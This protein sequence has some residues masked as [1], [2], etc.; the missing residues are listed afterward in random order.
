MAEVPNSRSVPSGHDEQFVVQ[1]DEDLHC[2]ICSLPSKEPVLTRCGHRFCRQCLEEFLR[3]QEQEGH[4]ITCPL[5]REALE[6][7]KDIFPDKL[8]E[9]K[10]LSHVIKCPNECCDWR[11]ELR[12][13]E[14]HLASCPWKTVSCTNEKCGEH[15]ARKDLTEHV[16]NT[17]VWRILRCL[18]CQEHHPQCQMEAHL[19]NCEGLLTACPNNCGIKITT[20]KVSDHVENTCPLTE[21]P[22]PYNWLGCS[23]KIQREVLESH[24]QSE[25]RYHLHLSCCKLND[26]KNEV[27]NLQLE[28]EELQGQEDNHHNEIEGRAQALQYQ[29]EE[30]AQA[31]QNQFE[32]RVQALQNQFEQREQALQNQFEERAQ[33]LQNQ[34]EERVQAVQNQFEERVQALQNQFEEREQALQ[35][36]FEER[37][38]A[39]E[40][41]FEDREQALQNHFEDRLHA[42]QKHFEDRVQ[43]LENHFEERINLLTLTIDRLRKNLKFASIVFAVTVVILAALSG[44]SNRESAVLNRLEKN[45]MRNVEEQSKLEMKMDEVQRRLEGNVTDLRSQSEG[46][47][48]EAQKYL[49]EKTDLLTLDSGEH[50][51]KIREFE[52]KIQALTTR[53]DSPR[54][55]CDAKATAWDGPRADGSI[56]Y[57]DQHHVECPHGMFVASFQLKKEYYWRRGQR[58]HKVGYHYHCCKFIL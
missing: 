40:N 34:F 22:C 16:A 51:Q 55:V 31:L 3:R 54:V 27:R 8:A 37:V 41:H 56:I 13:K 30:R 47:M 26:T 36:Q 32:E 17:C 48:N 11:G 24:L 33:T 5:D 53:L 4:Q 6:R 12:E 1:P 9:R 29:F 38:Q 35:N 39:L 43:A 58:F 49:S 15:L 23:L 45:I 44:M 19:E 21:V 2:I 7:N 25:T 14:N 42:F 52:T 18:Y 28:V 20:E 57:L 46:K 10:V 50:K